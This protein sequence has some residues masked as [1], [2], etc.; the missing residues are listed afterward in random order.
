MKKLFKGVWA[1]LGCF[2]LLVL[3]TFAI[4]SAGAPVEADLPA[5]V[6]QLLGVAAGLISVISQVDAQISE[7]YKM[8][9]PRWFRFLWNLAAG[10]YKYS[11]NIGS[12]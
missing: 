4:A 10:N 11:Q 9:W 5:W 8:K 6:Y 7:E 3:P 12:V 2:V 1:Y